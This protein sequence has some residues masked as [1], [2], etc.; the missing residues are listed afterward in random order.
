MTKS[1][2]ALGALDTCVQPSHCQKPSPLA[3]TLKQLV[4]QPILAALQFLHFLADRDSVGQ[5]VSPAF[6]RLRAFSRLSG[7]S[8]RPRTPRFPSQETLPRGPFSARVNAFSATLK[9]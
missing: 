2:G 1:C 7:G 5:A 8:L 6:A 4:G 9:T 3:L